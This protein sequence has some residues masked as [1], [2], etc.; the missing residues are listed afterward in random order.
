MTFLPLITRSNENEWWACTI[1]SCWYLHTVILSSWAELLQCHKIF[2][3]LCIASRVWY[4]KPFLHQ[5]SLVLYVTKRFALPF[6]RAILLHYTPLQ[7][8]KS[9]ISI[10]PT[11]FAGLLFVTSRLP[12]AFIGAGGATLCLY[13]MRGLAFNRKI[14]WS[15]EV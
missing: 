14:S 4:K 8:Q 11:Y 5:L 13:S 10:I 9:R 7:L 2:R 3:H 15:L 1:M 6:V 12:Y